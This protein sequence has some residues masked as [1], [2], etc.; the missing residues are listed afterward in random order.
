VQVCEDRGAGVPIQRQSILSPGAAERECS[1]AFYRNCKVTAN[2]TEFA[3]VMGIIELFEIA[4]AVCTV[5]IIM[6]ALVRRFRESRWLGRAHAKL[7]A[8]GIGKSDG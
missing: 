6:S 4:M 7:A 1:A 3:T 5:W 8:S 2:Q